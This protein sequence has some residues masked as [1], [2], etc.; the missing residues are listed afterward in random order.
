MKRTSMTLP[1]Q[2]VDDLDFIASKIAVTRSALV[3]EILTSSAADLRKVVE[4][5]FPDDEENSFR[6]RT[7][8]EVARLIRTQLNVA[9]QNLSGA[10]AQ[11][12]EWEH[13]LGSI[14]DDGSKH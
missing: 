10:N 9:K 6:R 12:D 7:G 5:I 3:S 2:L 8:S 4:A 14:S 11:L 13:E 1:D